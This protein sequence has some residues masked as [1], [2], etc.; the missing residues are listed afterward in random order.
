MPPVDRIT[1]APCWSAYPVELAHMAQ[2]GFAPYFTAAVQI[3]STGEQIPLPGGGEFT[4]GRVGGNQPVLPNIDLTPFR[5]YETG[6]SRLHA[7]ILLEKEKVE[8]VDLGSANGTQVNGQRIAA[9]DPYPLKDG[10]ILSLGKLEV[11]I[12]I[13]EG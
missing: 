10:D 3:L 2:P 9:H 13:R 7:T 1:S 11:R 4:L 8:I 12:L 6:V 5:A